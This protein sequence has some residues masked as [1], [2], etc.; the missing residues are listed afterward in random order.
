MH[1]YG[2]GYHITDISHRAGGPFG[3][4]F[5]VR[6]G[7]DHLSDSI[8]QVFSFLGKCLAVAGGGGRVLALTLIIPVMSLW[9]IGRSIGIEG[10]NRGK[11][12]G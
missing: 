2:Q 7:P 11:N 12:F 4:L 3:A 5:S 6:Q 1:I 10:C 8:L 9:A